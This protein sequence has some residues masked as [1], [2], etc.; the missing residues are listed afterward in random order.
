MI[1]VVESLPRFTFSCLQTWSGK[2][3]NGRN[4]TTSGLDIQIFSVVTTATA[5]QAQQQQQQEQ[6]QHHL[7]HL[8]H[9]HLHLRCRLLQQQRTH[10]HMPRELRSV[11]NATSS[12]SNGMKCTNGMNIRTTSVSRV[13]VS[14][15]GG[16]VRVFV[17]LC[18]LTSPATAE[19]WGANTNT[20]P[21]CYLRSAKAGF[22]CSGDM[23][24]NTTC[25]LG[26]AC[27]E[28]F[29]HYPNATLDVS[30]GS[31]CATISSNGTCVGR[32]SGDNP[33]DDDDI[34][35]GHEAKKPKQG[36]IFEGFGAWASFAAA[37]SVLTTQLCYRPAL[38]QQMRPRML[39]VLLML[40]ALAG[41]FLGLTYTP[42]FWLSD[43]YHN[44][45][46]TR[47]VD[48]IFLFIG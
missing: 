33:S 11:G 32:K 4:N 7:H 16:A 45:S 29:V 48:N 41:L 5:N 9:P 28:C 31:C 40:D 43:K 1:V 17:S 38:T 26:T 12:T 22:Q 44:L 27:S 8:L 6:G 42:I 10:T 34:Y 21:T 47:S 39:L 30:S 2:N 3:V 13:P 24:A 35:Q 37:F 19:C 46:S 14:L 23:C 15:S 18:L 20:F 36:L 25:S